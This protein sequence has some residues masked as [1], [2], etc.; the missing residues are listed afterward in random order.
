MIRIWIA[1]GV[2]SVATSVFADTGVAVIKG[3]VDNS[4]VGGTVNFQDTKEGLKVSAKLTGLP[5][6]NHGFHIHEFGGC[7]DAGKA[8]GGH[9]N[10]KESKHGF[11]PKDGLHKAHGGDMGN[12]TAAADGTASLDIVLPKITLTGNNSIAGRAV[13]VHEKTD[14]FSQPVGNAGSRIG[15]GPIVVTGK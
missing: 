11:L 3:T 13:V 10:P 2:L 4:S 7:G 8:A 5:S 9:F 1:L 15:C 12:I 14:D 6:G